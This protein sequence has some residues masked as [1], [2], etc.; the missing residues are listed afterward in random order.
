[1]M[2]TP[3]QLL[4]VHH[5]P[6]C[7]ICVCDAEENRIAKREFVRHNEAKERLSVIC[8]I[9]YSKE[10][11][12]SCPNLVFLATNIEPQMLESQSTAQKTWSLA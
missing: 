6:S 10:K 9:R 1:M 2:F 11:N 8:T 7:D 4:F 12:V 5:T 3:L